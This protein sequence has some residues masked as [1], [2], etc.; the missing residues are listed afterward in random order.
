M[1]NTILQFEMRNEFKLSCHF[2]T[3]LNTP[4]VLVSSSFFC[5]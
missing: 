3:T 2:A 4:P 1:R 5:D